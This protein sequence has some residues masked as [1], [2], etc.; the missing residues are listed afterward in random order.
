MHGGTLSL[1]GPLSAPSR[2]IDVSSGNVLNMGSNNVSF[3]G[4]ITGGGSLDKTGLG[5]LTLGGVSPGFTGPTMVSEGGLVLS[6]GSI[7]SSEVTIA[8]GASLRGNGTTGTLHNDGLVFPGASIGV[9]NV[10]G[11]Y[12]QTGLL[13]IEIAPDGTSDLV[14]VTGNANLGGTLLVEPVSDIGLYME[15]TQYAILTADEIFGDFDFISEDTPFDFD[16]FFQDEPDIAFLAI[17]N[18]ST[19]ILPVSQLQNSNAKSVGNYLLGFNLPAGSDL[20]N[21]L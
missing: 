7:P 11:D 17:L 18:S 1:T 15:G 5:T 20:V 10:A 13:E 8:P 6:G 16:V 21:V 3:G 19:L 9:L 12:N 14:N 4:P 2:P